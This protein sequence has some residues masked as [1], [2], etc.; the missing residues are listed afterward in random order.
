VSAEGAGKGNTWRGNY[1][2]DY[3]GFDRDG[4]GR[5]DT[6]HEIWI[7]ADRIWMET[8]MAAFFRSSPA[9]EL[10]DFLERLAPFSLPYRILGDPAP[11]MH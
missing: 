2:D 5:G 3:Q 8:P 11:R 1:W 7:H 4:D 9:L 10:L 6:P